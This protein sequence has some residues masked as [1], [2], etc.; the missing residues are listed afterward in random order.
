MNQ[1]ISFCTV[2][3]NR[4]H[5]V[6]QTIKENIINNSSCENV[7][8]VLLDYNSSDGLEDWVRH[9]LSQYIESG[10]LIYY[11]TNQPQYF[12]RSHARNVAFKLASGDILCNVDGD[13]LIG[14]QFAT[15]VRNE[16]SAT[17]D[18]FLT[19]DSLQL[20][21]SRDVCGRIA[22]R[23]SDFLGV[24]GFDERMADY[25]WEDVDLC[26]RLQRSGLKKKYISDLRYLQAL[27]HHDTLRIENEY[28]TKNFRFL[29]VHYID[30]FNMKL[31]VLYKNMIYERGT[32]L[33]NGESPPTLLEKVWTKGVYDWNENILMLDTAPEKKSFVVEDNSITIDN[34]IYYL[35]K[36]PSFL[37][38][39]QLRLSM[40]TNYQV[41]IQNNERG[42]DTIN[43]EGFGRA[44][45][46][47][48]FKENI[49][50][51]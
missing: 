42:L 35:A 7:E 39:M 3:M 4:L 40:I 33:D 41:L 37:E 28:R 21:V 43:Q 1:R 9:E 46:I 30:P 6:Q 8:F 31:I 45:L 18:F 12:H 22:V 50:T 20:G 10:L 38:R 48:N 26:S 47:K 36:T 14:P 23:K 24:R 51:Y 29:W 2:C 34:E 44:D 27:T 11:K 25:G 13:N 16:F 5:H 17:S 15:Y 19:V 49:I 32:L